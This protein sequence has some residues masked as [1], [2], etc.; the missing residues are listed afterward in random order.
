MALARERNTT[1][2]SAKKGL[3]E[4]TGYNKASLWA[5]GKS[6][7][8]SA[9]ICLYEQGILELYEILNCVG[10]SRCSFYRI[11]RLYDET[12]CVKPRS[13][14]FGRPH[15]LNLEDL[16]YLLEVVHPD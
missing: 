1:N 6:Q 16:H 10:F 15:I 8:M 2:M 12:G 11:K 4:K 3:S 14:F 9:V 13:R 7:M 5:T